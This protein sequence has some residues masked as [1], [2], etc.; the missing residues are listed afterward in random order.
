MNIGEHDLSTIVHSF[1]KAALDPAQWMPAMTS[2]S[3]A[4]GAVG[5]ALELTDLN[6]GAAYVANSAALDGAVRRDYEER[7]F[8]INPRINRA[9]SMPLGQVADDSVLMAGDAPHKGEFLDWL[10]RAPYHYIIGGKILNAG[11]HVGFL[12]ANYAKSHGMVTQT[13]HDVF[14]IL[15]PQ[16]INIVEVGRALSAN[17]L[18]HDLTDLDA[19]LRVRRQELASLFGLTER[20][21]DVAALI[22]EGCNIEQTGEQLAISAY[23]VRQHLKA[24]FGKVGVSRQAELVALVSRLG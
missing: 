5:C 9:L 13:H 4:M 14:A 12:T 20:E 8:H 21:A 22:S 2:L 3:E 24:V 18:R 7:I 16:L 19:P 23:T 11:G 15:T 17:R 1:A 10:E 6:T